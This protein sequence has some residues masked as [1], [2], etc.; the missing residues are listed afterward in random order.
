M[1]LGK[2][3]RIRSSGAPT[4]GHQ[5]RA[6][7]WFIMHRA[8][9][10]SCRRR[11]LSSNVRRCPMQSAKPKAEPSS[12]CGQPVQARAGSTPNPSAPRSGCG[13][14]KTMVVRWLELRAHQRSSAR[15]RP[16]SRFGHRPSW[17]VSW[18]SFG[19]IAVRCQLSFVVGA[20]PNSAF[21]RTANSVAPWPGG[22]G[23]YHRPRGQG[24]TL[25]SA[26]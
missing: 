21:K 23:V 19:T 1:G 4:A 11:P 2:S 14:R 26:A 22:R 17:R 7:P 5:A 3:L 15:P 16:R 10:A 6:A 25:S 13:D 12:C 9:L 24:A 18:P 8:G 20:A